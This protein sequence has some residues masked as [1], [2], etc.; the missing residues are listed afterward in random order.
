GRSGAGGNLLR[1]GELHRRRRNRRERSCGGFLREPARSGKAL[2]RVSSVQG[3]SADS[4]VSSRISQALASL[5][6]RCT[7]STETPRTLADSSTLM[8][9]KKRNSTTWL[10]RGSK[11]PRTVRA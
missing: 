10:L 5:Q 3:S 2:Q 11:R 9:P 6:S 1:G 4:E 7:V 8:P